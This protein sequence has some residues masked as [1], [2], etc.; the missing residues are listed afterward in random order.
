MFEI[1]SSTKFPII[2]IMD[3]FR[4]NGIEYKFLQDKETGFYR[5]EYGE[6][7]SEEVFDR[8]EDIA[9]KFNL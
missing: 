8:L 2:L 3:L 5:I 1:E 6:I 9:L 4:A 7:E